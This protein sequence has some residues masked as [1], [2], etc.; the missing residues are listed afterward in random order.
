MQQLI[1]NQGFLLHHLRDRILGE[2]ITMTVWADD[3]YGNWWRV[4]VYEGG[5]RE[6]TPLWYLENLFDEGRRLDWHGKSIVH[7]HLYWICDDDSWMH[8][9]NGENNWV[10][11]M[12]FMLKWYFRWI[13]TCNSHYGF[14]CCEFTNTIQIMDFD[15]LNLQIQFKSWILMVWIY[16]Y[17]SHYGFWWFEFTNTIHSILV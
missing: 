4:L 11:E 6:W 8:P 10:D 14:W 15:G 3:G 16:K 1:H 12:N 5:W 2:E 17:N 13:Y 9:G 7:R